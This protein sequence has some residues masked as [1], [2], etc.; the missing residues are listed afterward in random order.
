MVVAEVEPG[1]PASEAGLQ[2]GDV[3]RQVNRAPVKDVQ[4][5]SQ[6]IEKTKGQQAAIVLLLQRRGSTLFAAVTPK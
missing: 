1:S 6:K 2:P 4:D 3:I 5:F